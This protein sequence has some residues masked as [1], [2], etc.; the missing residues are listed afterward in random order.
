MCVAVELVCDDNDDGGVS[1][2]GD[3][4]NNTAVV[5]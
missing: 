5:G 2:G 3:G 4:G 1:V